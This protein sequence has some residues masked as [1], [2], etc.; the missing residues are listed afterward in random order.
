VEADKEF[1]TA[2]LWEKYI[3][4]TSELGQVEEA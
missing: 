2:V 1:L 4:R 3:G